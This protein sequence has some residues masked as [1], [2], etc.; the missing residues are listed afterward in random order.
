[1]NVKTA[2]LKNNLS[3]YLRCVR[4]GKTLTVFDRDTPIATLSPVAPASTDEDAAWQ[5]ERAAAV[6]RAKKNGI[7]IDLPLC[8]PTKPLFQDVRPV[9]APDGRT[10]LRTVELIRG[11]RDW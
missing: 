11:G 5:R 6:A 10:D 9:T 8:R 7:K 2:D 1:M 3:K 4:A